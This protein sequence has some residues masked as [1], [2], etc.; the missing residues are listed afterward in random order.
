VALIAGLAAPSVAADGRR[1]REERIERDR[2]RPGRTA[3]APPARSQV[4]S[5]ARQT[6]RPAALP[7]RG[8]TARLRPVVRI[9][10]NVLA[11]RG[12]WETHTVKVLVEPG[13]WE[14]RTIP[15]VYQTF[16]GRLGRTIL[17]CV[18]PGRVE[19]VWVPDRYE[20]R[21]ERVWV[22]Y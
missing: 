2:V 20:Y 3:A 8:A 22:T 13:H 21:T 5:R 1:G 12:H 6:H 11:P 4:Q 19:R 18:R 10:R 17:L 7:Q 15:P 9:L 14:T 16:R